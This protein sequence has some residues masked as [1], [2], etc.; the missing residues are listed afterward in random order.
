MAN[1]SLLDRYSGSLVGLACG[2][3]I[4]TSASFWPRSFFSPALATV[5]DSLLL[6]LKYWPDGTA[7]AFCLAVSLLTMKKINVYDQLTRLVN[8]W[9]QGH[10]STEG[11]SLDIGRSAEQALHD[12]EDRGLAFSGAADTSTAANRALMR[13]APVALY[14]YPATDKVIQYAKAGDSQQQP[15]Q[16]AMDCCRLLAHIL[17]Q[18]LSG[19]S[20]TQLLDGTAIAL[21]DAK[22]AALARGEYKHKNIREIAKTPRCVDALEAALW[23]FHKSSSFESAVC[24]AATLGDDADTTAAIVGQIAG[25]H[26]GLEAIPAQWRKNLFRTNEIA[27]LAKCLYDAASMHHPLTILKYSFL[28]KFSGSAN[29]ACAT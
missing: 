1:P 14:Y 21:S 11:T 7:M 25:A 10:L 24:M 3:A 19:K 20:H 15:S 27:A 12:F 29:S 23:A 17:V 2:D 4:G 16:Q 26:Y 6:E 8:W 28:A 18:A 5:P 22:V 13:L 9:K